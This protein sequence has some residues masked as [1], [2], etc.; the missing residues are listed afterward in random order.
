MEKLDNETPEAKVR[1]LA[2][3]VLGRYTADIEDD[4]SYDS[5]IEIVEAIAKEDKR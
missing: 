1:R 2:V 5:V 4:Y 3:D